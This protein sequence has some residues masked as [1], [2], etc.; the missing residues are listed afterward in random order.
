M[1]SLPVSFCICCFIASVCHC[2]LEQL[3]EDQA[4]DEHCLVQGL[5]SEYD[6][7]LATNDTLERKLA[8]LDPT[9]HQ[10]GSGSKKD[11]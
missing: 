5:E 6:R 1:L 11:W 10:A 8:R 9:H 4:T 2:E 3:C 7:L